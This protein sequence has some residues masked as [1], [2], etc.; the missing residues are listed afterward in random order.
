MEK[1]KFTGKPGPWVIEKSMN[2]WVKGKNGEG[3]ICKISGHAG[4]DALTKTDR[5]NMKLIRAAPELL[6]QLKSAR[7]VLVMA[8]LIDKT[9]TCMKEAD[10][11]DK[12][13]ATIIDKYTP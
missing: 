1:N 11:C 12:L 3:D 4:D 9:N 2:Y 8:S 7:D 13:L 10:A 6:E 5:A